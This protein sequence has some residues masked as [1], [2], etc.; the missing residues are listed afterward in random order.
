LYHDGP[1][2][3]SSGIEAYAALKVL[4][5]DPAREE[6]TRALAVIHRMG[7]VAHARVFTKIWL[8][9][10]GEY[11][12]RGVP[13]M[14]PELVWLPKSAPLNLYDFSCWAR[15]TVAPLL[16]VLSRRP[17]R[18]LGVELSELVVPGT[19][20]L[21]TRVPGSGPFWWL[22]Q[23]LK[24]YDRLPLHPGRS[25]ARRRLVRWIVERQEADGG[26]GGIQPPWVYS[27][28]ALNL[29]GRSLED[30]VM[31]K[32]L[33]G[34]EGFALSDGD[35]WRFQA[36]MSPV[37]DTAWAVRALRAAGLER[38]HESLQR[39]VGWLLQ[40]QIMGGGDWQVRSPGLEECGGWAFEFENDHY[41]DVD[42]TA[43]VVCALLE[44]APNARVRQAVYRAGRWVQAMRSSNGA[45]AAFDRDNDSKWP[46]RLAFADFGALTD[47]PTEDVTAHVLEM[48]AA[49]GA[50]TTDPLVAG[51]V[52]YLRQTQQPGGAWHGRWGV[53]Y[54]YGSWCV[55]S[56]LA[57][58]DAE[59]QRIERALGWLASVQ[60][61]D[62]GW[63][64]SCHSY[65]D[66]S[67]AGVGVSTPSQTAWAVMSFQLAGRGA[68]PA[69]AAGIR[70]L[71]ERQR[72]GTWDEPEF[73]GTGFPRDFYINYHLYRHVFPTMALALA[74]VADD[75][76]MALAMAGD[77]KE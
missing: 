55:I 74:R 6:M 36:C 1:A 62:G 30:P 76:P 70:Y 53:N 20:D 65:D 42:D 72:E 63:G 56:A 69:V 10:F 5:L 16:I 15:Q 43:V 24:L 3:L 21:L 2:D 13:S 71:Q 8:A 46:Y 22:D 14:P 59:H 50:T 26:W 28:I 75:R 61:P 12:W 25:R 31:A 44:G 34:M 73:T 4:G 48:M 52:E 47:P 27:L 23:L 19:E 68:E 45:W 38:S 60:N 39:A 67:F 18:Q 11:P 35:G 54:I 57:A 7:G 17:R 41:P 33:S 49:N 40:E 9:L 77:S 37:W 64:E 29:Q 66:P 58:L 32:G 51:G